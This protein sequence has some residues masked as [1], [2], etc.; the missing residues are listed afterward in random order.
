MQSEYPTPTQQR[1][2]LTSEQISL[3]EQTVNVNNNGMIAIPGD[4]VL[5]KLSSFHRLRP[6]SPLIKSVRDIWLD[7]EIINLYTRLITAR[8]IE[9][10]SLPRVYCLDTFFWP[11]LKNWGPNCLSEKLSVKVYTIET[12]IHR[13]VLQ[14][15]I[16]FSSLY[17]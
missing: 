13:L 16:T 4:K 1:L 11:K 9:D 15:S 6:M 8:S 3:Y 2:E 12:L 17:S 10:L 5:R 7:D 14:I